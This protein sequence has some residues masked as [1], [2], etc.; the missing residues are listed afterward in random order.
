M[1]ENVLAADLNYILQRSTSVWDELRNQRLFITG[2]TGFFGIWLLEAIAWANHKLNLNLTTLVLTR[3]AT[4]FA[5]KAPHIAKD[6]LIHFHQ[7]DVR[8]FV[9]PEGEF[10]HIIHAATDA[11]ATLNQENPRLMKDTILQGTRHTLE[12]AA[13][14][15]AKKFLFV[16]SGA[17]Y[18]KQP[19]HLENIDEE[20]SGRAEISN[21][22]SAYAVG[23]QAAEL[24]CLQHAKEH[25]YEIKIARCF[26]FVGPYLPLD[27]HFAIGNFIRDGLA[28]KCIQVNGDGT[29][30]RSYLYAADL[31]IWLLHILCRGEPSVPYNVGSDESISIAELASLVASCFNPMPEVNISKPAELGREPERYV[32]CVK[33]IT[34]AFNLKE[35]VSLQDALHKTIV[36]YK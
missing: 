8:D 15:K 20:Y 31:V 35:I 10:S 17:I 13:K 9:F 1:N 18:G 3:N 16:S 19:S 23:K 4:A 30:Y 32:P 25:N 33:R 6:P 21:A 22:S 27:I 29:A 12:C 14:L 24:E 5:K 36:F 11:S 26:A 34:K 28:G 7:G 2:G